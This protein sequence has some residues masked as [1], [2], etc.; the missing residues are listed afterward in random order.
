MRIDIRAFICIGGIGE[1][2]NSIRIQIYVIF[3][4][5]TYQQIEGYSLFV[6]IISS[7]YSSLPFSYS[8]S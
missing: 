7:N 8:D 5:K 1:S 2:V 3:T 6:E 4:Y